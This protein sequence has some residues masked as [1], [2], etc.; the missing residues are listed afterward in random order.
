MCY[1]TLIHRNIEVGSNI[2]WVL[3]YLGPVQ[4]PGLGNY[5]SLQLFTQQNFEFL[6]KWC[7]PERRGYARNHVCTNH[8]ISEG[9]AGSRCQYFVSKW[10]R[11]LY[12]GAARNGAQHNKEW[13]FI[14][15]ND[16]LSSRLYYLRVLMV[17]LTTLPI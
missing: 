16:F 3:L 4:Q 6:R 5:Q 2:H 13:Y 8:G 7:R 12:L 14:H 9:P 10:S 11:S 15:Y 17:Y 1:G